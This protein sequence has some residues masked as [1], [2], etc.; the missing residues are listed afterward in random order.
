M[1]TRTLVAIVVVFVQSHLYNLRIWSV[2]SGETG[3]GVMAG[4]DL[5]E[6][7]PRHELSFGIGTQR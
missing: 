6:A 5:G 1:K 7:F 4:S 3:H 2:K